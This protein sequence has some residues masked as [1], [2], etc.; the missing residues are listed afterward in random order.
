M[1]H[2]AW[3]AIPLVLCCLSCVWKVL[4]GADRQPGQG[5]PALGMRGERSLTG[6]AR[7]REASPLT[8]ALM[9]AVEVGFTEC[10]WVRGRTQS[11]E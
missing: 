1:T 3:A 10:G 7:Q 9:G 8:E 11:W 5:G 6:G 2:S 4:G